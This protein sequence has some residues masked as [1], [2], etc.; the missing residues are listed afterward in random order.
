VHVSA[1]LPPSRPH[2]RCV[3][4]FEGHTNRQQPIGV[5]FSP[6]MRFVGCG[7]ED[8]SAYLFDIGSG[9]PVERLGAGG[10]SA[11]GAGAS[12]GGHTD[13]VSD[14]AFSPVHPQLVTACFDARLR[15]YS[16]AD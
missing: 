11:S 8:K 4:R 14:I 12:G 16:E 1:A 3:R 7:S 2:Y 9:A 6:C 15:F 10:G 13:V 5:A